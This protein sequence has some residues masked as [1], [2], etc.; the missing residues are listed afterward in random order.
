MYKQCSNST[1]A[2]NQT[3]N[4]I[5][6]MQAVILMSLSKHKHLYSTGLIFTCIDLWFILSCLCLSK[7]DANNALSSFTLHNVMMISKTS[8]GTVV[9]AKIKY[10]FLY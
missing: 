5:K 7:T 1:E 10:L 9:H 8:V 3:I 2:G 6:L 4:Y